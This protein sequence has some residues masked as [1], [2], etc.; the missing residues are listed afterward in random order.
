MMVDTG[1][2]RL[3][4]GSLLATHVLL[5]QA[6]PTTF[7]IKTSRST[8]VVTPEEIKRI[9]PQLAEFAG[10]MLGGLPHSDQ[11]A[12]GELY[13]RDLLTD[14]ARKS[15]QPMAER[16]GVDH[17]RMQQFVTSSTWDTGRCGRM[18]RGR[19]VRHGIRVRTARNGAIAA[20]AADLPAAI[21]ADLLG[22]H[23]NTAIR[24]VT[25]ARR[26]WADFLA[27]R[28]AEHDMPTQDE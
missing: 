27:A 5:D 4:D 26:D 17:Q 12:K 1:G 22:V 9:R 10:R 7:R 6:G 16:L 25:Y 2:T 13:T 11:R 19:L 28:A 24:W 8:W 21:L 20:L 15:M 18:W 23:I 14:G 3:D